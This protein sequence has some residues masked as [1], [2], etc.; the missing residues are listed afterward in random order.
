MR[1]VTV[2]LSDEEFESLNALTETRNRIL[3]T[4]LTISDTIRTA[5]KTL[6]TS[7]PHPIPE[8]HIPNDPIP[9]IV[10]ICTDAT[11]FTEMEIQKRSPFR[12]SMRIDRLPQGA[13]PSY[14]G[15]ESIALI[16]ENGGIDLK[17]SNKNYLIDTFEISDIINT[18]IHCN[19]VTPENVP[20]IAALVGTEAGNGIARIETRM[21]MKLM[22]EA[23]P[24]GRCLTPLQINSLGWNGEPIEHLICGKTPSKNIAEANGNV[25]STNTLI[26]E[27]EDIPNDSSFL[28]LRA[29]IGIFIIRQDV[30]LLPCTENGLLSIV[31][32]EEVG[33]AIT[34][35]NLA[36]VISEDDLIGIGDKLHIPR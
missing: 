11:P 32:F 28:V 12:R 26:L 29:P 34:N 36:M 9:S 17:A 14:D 7:P 16:N 22:K 19:E 24:G 20:C 4:P 5:I 23:T 27:C 21:M 25:C 33:M 31:A 1:T 13:R 8:P 35:R 30:T 18:D 6:P 10:Q 15:G 3:G 2:K